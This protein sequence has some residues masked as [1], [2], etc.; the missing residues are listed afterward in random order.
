M[1]V[2]GD[3]RAMESLLAFWASAGVDATLGETP[4]NR[5]LAAARPVRAA[6]PATVTPLPSPTTR[7]GPDVAAAIATAR[8]AAAA[9]DDLES[10]AA[11][12]AAF[13][14]CPL[15][16]DG[17]RQ[18]VFS[19]GNPTADIIV[20]GEG[21]GRDEDV[22]GAPFVGRAGKL[23]DRMLAAAGLTD[24]VF[25]TN[26]VFWRPP[27][28]RTPTPAEQ[29]VCQPFVEKAILLIKPQYL[30]LAGGAS[31]KSMLQKDEGILSLRGRWFEWSSSDESLTLPALPTLHPAFLLRQPAAKKR[32]WGD[33]LTV[34]ERV[35]RP[36][37]DG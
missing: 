28:N 15:K 19:R 32:A 4:V 24:R 31:A 14:G 37:R 35:D 29:A 21:P 3:V 33:L 5:L 36:E 27:G 30:L 8:E 18:S 26:T 12:I 25:I 17:A 7:A 9:A 2:A 11:A 16:F 23:L 10:L 20:I 34:A 1:S 22:A 6:P 13:D